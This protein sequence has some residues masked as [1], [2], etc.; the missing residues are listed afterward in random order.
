MMIKNQEPL[1]KSEIKD[2]EN[3]KL[4]VSKK[5]N[6]ICRFV[7]LGLMTL[8][9]GIWFVPWQQFVSGIGKVAVFEPLAR[10]IDIQAPVSGTI[11]R[12]HIQEG[13]AVKKG[14]LLA[15]IEDNDPKLLIHLQAQ[16]DALVRRYQLGQ[17]RVQELSR[18]IEQQKQEQLQTEDQVLQRLNAEEATWH[19]AQL[20]QTRASQLKPH[21]LIS[22]R[23]YELAIQAAATAKANYQ[24]ALSNIKRTQKNY[25]VQQA[26]FAAQKN[27]AEMEL[28]TIEREMKS[29]QIQIHQNHRQVIYSPSDSTVLNIQ[30]NE[31]TYLRPGSPIAVLIP[32]T[33]ERYVQ[34]WLHGNDAPLIRARQH[35]S[36]G[37]EISGSLVRLQ[38]EGWPAIQMIGW[39]SLAVGTFGGEVIFMDATD[40]GKGFFRIWVAPDTKNAKTP[41]WPPVRY[42]RQGVRVQGWV[43][44]KKIPLWQEIWRQFNGLSPFPS[45]MENEIEKS[46]K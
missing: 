39:P 35:L 1:E 8:L 46:T 41:N 37:S 32:D 15:E 16:Y 20:N 5:I 45:E 4:V 24:V 38:F 2:L 10:R 12:L 19:T 22:E 44:L 17:Y 6:F 43:L 29:L 36:S 26:G 21:G 18:Q 42:L 33:A 14:Q 28:A 40:N 11:R 3:S 27:G 31:G 9:L 7:F 25:A 23:D 13:Q 30:V 34:L